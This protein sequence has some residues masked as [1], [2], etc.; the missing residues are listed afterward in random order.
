MEEKFVFT[1]Q[2]Q[3]TVLKE[4]IEKK[5]E[6]GGSSKRARG[7]DKDS[8]EATISYWNNR[9]YNGFNRKRIGDMNHGNETARSGGPLSAS[10][11]NHRSGGVNGKSNLGN[12]VVEKTGGMGDKN[13]KNK[14]G[15]KVK[16][17]GEEKNKASTSEGLR[18]EVLEDRLEDNI[19]VFEKGIKKHFKHLEALSDITNGEGSADLPKET[20]NLADEADN[21]LED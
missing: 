3:P 10:N 21:I 20:P 17:A 19:I 9:N 12:N 11:G 7:E 14:L 4:S 15:S 1:A 6:I 13:G 5:F 2:A 16:K 8:T 18:F